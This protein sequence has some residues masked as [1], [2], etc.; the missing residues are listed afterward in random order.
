[1]MDLRLTR[2]Y[3]AQQGIHQ[4]EGLLFILSD[5]NKVTCNKIHALEYKEYRDLCQYLVNNNQPEDDNVLDIDKE[6]NW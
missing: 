5:Y 4:P 6:N 1:M 3:P 2:E